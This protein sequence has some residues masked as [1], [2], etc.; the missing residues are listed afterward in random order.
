MDN[1]WGAERAYMQLISK[2]NIEF[3]FSLCVIYI[4]N[5]YTC[6]IPFKDKKSI[7]IIDAFQKNLNEWNHKPNQIWVDK[8][9]EFY[10]GFI[11]SWLEKNIVRN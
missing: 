1:I 8:N 10:N 9:S 11:K 4:Y 7:T 6:F 5:K 3:R 2:F